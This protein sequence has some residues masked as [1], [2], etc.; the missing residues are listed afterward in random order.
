[1]YLPPSPFDITSNAAHT[2]GTSSL[3]KYKQVIRKATKLDLI[4]NQT[5]QIHLTCLSHIYQV[6][7][8]RPSVKYWQKCNVPTTWQLSTSNKRLSNIPFMRTRPQFHFSV[9]IPGRPS[10]LLLQNF[11]KETVF[12]FYFHNVCCK[13]S[14]YLIALNISHF[15]HPVVSS[16]SLCPYILLTALFSDTLNHVM[17]SYPM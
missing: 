4:I 10:V 5:L 2:L 8:K 12:I 6:N 15:F 14:P 11:Q 3:G 16:S 1:M 13:P 17:G 7:G 9:T